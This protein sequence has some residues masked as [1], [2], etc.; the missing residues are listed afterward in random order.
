[1]LLYAQNWF[2]LGL[3]Q[4]FLMVFCWILFGCVIYTGV[5]IEGS[6]QTRSVCRCAL[7]EDVKGGSKRVE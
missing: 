4:A 3:P 7:E 1:M 5:G 6:S 2:A